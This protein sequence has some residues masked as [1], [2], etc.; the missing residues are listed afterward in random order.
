MGDNIPPPS[1]SLSSAPLKDQEFNPSTEPN[2]ESQPNCLKITSLPNEF[3]FRYLQ[4]ADKYEAISQDS[5][6]LIKD[7]HEFH[8]RMQEL[9]YCSAELRRDVNDYLCARDMCQV[10]LSDQDGL[11]KDFNDN[12]CAR[13]MYQVKFSNQDG[14]RKDFNHNPCAREMSHLKLS[15]VDAD[16]IRKDFNDYLCAHGQSD[17]DDLRKTLDKIL[18]EM[19][20]VKLS[21][22][23]EQLS[24]EPSSSI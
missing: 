18:C 1:S 15:D 6:V 24:E 9:R 19:C 11:R 3:Q 7:M 23:D 14:L 10:K 17:R 5:D 4:L 2:I 16:E 21:D 8:R 20:Q 12:P 13:E 22:Q